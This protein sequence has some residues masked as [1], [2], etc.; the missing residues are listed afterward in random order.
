MIRGTKDRSGKQISAEER[1]HKMLKGPEFQLLHKQL[2]AILGKIQ[3]IPADLGTQDLGL[4][5]TQLLSL[6]R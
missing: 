1:L 2:D 3:V 4:S 6:I 5:D